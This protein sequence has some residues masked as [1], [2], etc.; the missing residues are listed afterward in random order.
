[1]KLTKLIPNIQR[2]VIIR[3]GFR[4]KELFNRFII[5]MMSSGAIQR[6][7]NVDKKFVDQSA[8]YESM[9]T[10]NV[11]TEGVM[12]LHIKYFVFMLAAAGA[13]AFVISALEWIFYYKHFLRIVNF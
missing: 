13:L 1:M 3:P 11:E 10:Y 9:S 4:Y 8:L 6:N 2:T 12:F 7:Q 5:K